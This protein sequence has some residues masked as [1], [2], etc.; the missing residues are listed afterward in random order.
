MIRALFRFAVMSTVMGVAVSS[1]VFAQAPAAPAPAQPAAAAPAQ[2][3]IVLANGKVRLGAVFYADWGFYDKT[4]FGPQFVTQTNFPGPGNDNFSSFDVH[5]TYIN[6]F[7]S[8]S[9]HVTLRVTPNIYR[10]AITGSADKAGAT[11]AIGPT[12]D[13]NLT[14]RLKYGYLEFGKLF[15][16]STLFKSTNVR[17]GQQ[18]NP[19]VDWEEALWDYRW[20]SL[21]PWNYLSLSSTHVGASLNGP[22]GK[23]G[24]T[25]L[26]YQ[27]GVFNNVSF[28]AFEYAEQKQ[29]MA[30][31][32]FYPMGAK[33]RF[34]GLGLTAFYDH[35]YTNSAPDTNAAVPVVRVA[36][37]AHY[38]TPNNGSLIGVEYDYGKNAFSTGNMFSGSAPQDL[39][40]I[41]ST[42]YA[43]MTKLA[44][45][46]LA[47][48]NTRQQGWNVFGRANLPHS[49]FSV[50]AWD[51]FFQPNTNVPTNPLDFYHVI[52]GLAYR[53]SPRWRVAFSSQ[54]VLYKQSQFT[55]PADALAGFNPPLAAANPAGIPNAVP[56]DIHA[57]FI[58]FE[59]T[60]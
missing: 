13:G 47:G 31:A 60:F 7:Y 8:P 25:Y 29:F 27:V 35:G 48:T 6:L 3:S 55:Y 50:F 34:Q 18:M 14:F 40:G 17:V 23:N 37:L 30:R 24:K 56:A 12:A 26:D 15:E 16:N 2:D 42:Q 57:Q 51:Q 36:A 1:S 20:L 33:T 38:T 5:R 43:G 4:G 10:E 53:V 54:Y 45:A 32:S 19:L 46:V 44:Q 22:I 41:G 11:G 39:F 52:A 58:N 49:K 59:F 21:T 28:H 9:D